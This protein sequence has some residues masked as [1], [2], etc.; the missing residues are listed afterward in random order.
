VHV[1]NRKPRERVDSQRYMKR[2]IHSLPYLT[3]LRKDYS[4]SIGERIFR[5]G[6]LS[7]RSVDASALVAS[8]LAFPRRFPDLYVIFCAA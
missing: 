5:S 4:F 1:M 3:K 6:L 2:E 8:N 7:K